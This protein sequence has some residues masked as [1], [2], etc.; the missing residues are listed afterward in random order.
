M[1]VNCPSVGLCPREVLELQ[2]LF[3]RTIILGIIVVPVVNE[4]SCTRELFVSGC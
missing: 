1:E 3:I 4:P 2:T